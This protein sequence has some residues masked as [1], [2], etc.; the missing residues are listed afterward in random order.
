MADT[1]N[2]RT[3]ALLVEYDGAPFCGWS[4]Q[5][6]LPSVE[7]AM[8]DSLEKLS[9]TVDDMRCAGRTDNGV[10]AT[11][12]VVSLRYQGPIEQERLGR[13]LA[14]VLPPEIT[15]RQAVEASDGF[16]ARADAKWRSYQYR[17]LARR[18]PSPTRAAHT[19]HHPRKLNRD[20]LHASAEA[21]LG[22]HDFTAFTP[23]ETNHRFFHRT[24]YVS[25]WVERGDELVFEIAGN[26]FLR[27]MVRNLAGTM[28]AVGRGDFALDRLKSLLNGGTR[29]DAW[30]TA[31]PHALCLVG[32][33]YDDPPS[34][35][36]DGIEMPVV[37]G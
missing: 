11:T 2:I 25:R 19:I 15:I 18:P 14:S 7:G 4:R 37:V 6:G 26:A 35:L 20:L 36:L 22:K 1:P 16:D 13:A 31:L 21:I 23:T 28:L 29:S 24:V 9:L 34:G 27:H 5:P 32:V 30:S 17:V 8:R 33:G 3:A 10:H 12:Q